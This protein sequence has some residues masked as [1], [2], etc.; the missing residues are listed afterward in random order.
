MYVLTNCCF[1]CLRM[2]RFL[3][4]RRSTDCRR[5]QM[6]WKKNWWKC[7]VTVS[8]SWIELLVLPPTPSVSYP[9]SYV[10]CASDY[11]GC[12]ICP[13]EYVNCLSDCCGCYT[14]VPPPLNCQGWLWVTHPYTPVVCN[15]SVV[16][17]GNTHIPPIVC[18]LSVITVGVTP[19]YPQEYV[20]GQWS[21]WVS[22]T[23]TPTTM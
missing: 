18:N 8:N 7:G 9:H 2:Q 14:H 1:C 17:V 3:C 15:L 20:S 12:H 19:I 16:T 13:E 10:N 4:T 6:L 23:L 22:Q 5:R 11:C 21:L